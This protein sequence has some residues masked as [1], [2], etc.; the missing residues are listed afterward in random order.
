MSK[1]TALQ[2]IRG[3]CVFQFL[4]VILYVMFDGIEK[5]EIVIVL[6]SLVFG[7]MLDGF[8]HNATKVGIFQHEKR[9]LDLELDQLMDEFE[10]DTD[11]E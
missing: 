4:I 1:N 2:L 9:K 3:L 11:Q 6:I 7:L 5:S 8:S 10:K